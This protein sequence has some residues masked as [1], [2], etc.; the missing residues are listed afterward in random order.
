MTEDKKQIV[1]RPVARNE[2]VFKVFNVLHKIAAEA[3]ETETHHQM[4]PDSAVTFPWHP[5]P[6]VLRRIVDFD[7]EVVVKLVAGN[8]GQG[9]NHQGTKYIF[10]FFMHHNLNNRTKNYCLFT[11]CCNFAKI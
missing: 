11:R 1:L 10:D 7:F 4:R 2:P 6:G 3:V 9:C 8:G 5:L